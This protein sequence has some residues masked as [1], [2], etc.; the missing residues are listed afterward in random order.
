ML[1]TQINKSS[2]PG[3]LI[4]YVALEMETEKKSYE[5][6]DMDFYS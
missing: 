4:G 5:N 6:N 2:C 3:R 1:Y